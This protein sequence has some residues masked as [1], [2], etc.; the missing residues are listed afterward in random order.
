[1]N[2]K[3]LSPEDKIIRAKKSEMEAYE[4]VTFICFVLAVL[5]FSVCFR[6]SKDVDAHVLISWVPLVGMGL[7]AMLWAGLTAIALRGAVRSRKQLAKLKAVA[8]QE[9]TPK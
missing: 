2:V 5:S 9:D 4:S 3:N 6:F 7:L 8:A 1:M